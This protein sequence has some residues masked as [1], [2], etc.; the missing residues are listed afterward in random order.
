MKKIALAVLLAT[1]MT[2]GAVLADNHTFSAGYAQ[3]EVK[4]FKDLKGVNLQYRYEFDSPFSVVGSFSWMKSD[5]DYTDRLS[6]DEISSTVEIK[7]YSLLVGPAY[8][9]NDYVSLYA[10][11]GVAHVKGEDNYTW[12]NYG[13]GYTETDTATAKGTGFAW[14]AGIIVNP[15]ENLSLTAG[16]EGTNVDLEGSRNINGFNIGVGYR[17]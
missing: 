17:F 8:R 7:Y 13:D 1:G 9:L 3:S 14:G 2:S 12:V 15:M 6:Q 10:L 16:Y 5:E 11:G 4:G